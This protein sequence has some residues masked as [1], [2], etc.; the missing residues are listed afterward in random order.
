M[1]DKDLGLPLLLLLL[2]ILLL[3][4]NA[5]AAVRVYEVAGISSTEVL[6]KQGDEL[7]LMNIGQKSRGIEIE[8]I[9][10]THALINGKKLKV[11]DTFAVLSD[12]W[13][14]M[15]GIYGSEH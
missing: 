3:L 8:K 10:F 15:E 13:M 14:P 6:I 4:V 5:L 1:K 2:L 11:G 9:M 12:G 7:F